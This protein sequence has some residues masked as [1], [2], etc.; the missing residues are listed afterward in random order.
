MQKNLK[1]PAIYINFLGMIAKTMFETRIKPFIISS[2][3]V[4]KATNVITEV[5]RTGMNVFSWINLRAY[6]VVRVSKLH[7]FLGRFALH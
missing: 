7:P 3:F 1:A 6:M 2:Y 4:R 5:A